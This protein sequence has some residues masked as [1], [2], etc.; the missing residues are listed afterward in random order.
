MARGPDGACGCGVGHPRAAPRIDIDVNP[1]TLRAR[2]N[3]IGLLFL[4]AAVLV[5]VVRDNQ[6]DGMLI[7]ALIL[8]GF[9][10]ANLVRARAV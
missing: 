3:T 6:V 7:L 1:S 8:F 5:G 10:M 2:R 4:A 9:G